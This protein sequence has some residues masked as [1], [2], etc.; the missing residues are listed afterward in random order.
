MIGSCVHADHEA[1]S[2]SGVDLISALEKATAPKKTLTHLR[3]GFGLA[4]STLLLALGALV[5]QL[6]LLQSQL[7]PG[8]LDPVLQ[9]Q[10]PVGLLAV[11]AELGLLP[12][13]PGASFGALSRSPTAHAPANATNAAR[14]AGGSSRGTRTLALG[15]V[16]FELLD[17]GVLCLHGARL[18]LLGLGLNGSSNCV[19]VLC[20]KHLGNGVGLGLGLRGGTVLEMDLRHLHSCGNLLEREALAARVGSV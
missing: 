5:P 4:H 12:L 9:T 13:A 11:I 6:L 16:G 17:L 2:E 15:N 19:V 14:R 18:H 20:W 7:G 1:R 10:A 3:E 8:L